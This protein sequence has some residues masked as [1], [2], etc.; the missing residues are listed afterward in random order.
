MYPEL[1]AAAATAVPVIV[2]FDAAE[3]KFWRS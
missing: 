1:V 3:E 2:V